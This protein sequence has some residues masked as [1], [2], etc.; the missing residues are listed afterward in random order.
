M[1]SKASTALKNARGLS[2]SEIQEIIDGVAKGTTRIW[3]DTDH[4]GKEYLQWETD[5]REK[6]K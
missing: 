4:A 5:K 6:A 1:D 2:M 3:V